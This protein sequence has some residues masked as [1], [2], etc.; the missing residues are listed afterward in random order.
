[1]IVI[2]RLLGGQACIMD[3]SISGTVSINGLLEPDAQL[4][5]FLAKVCVDDGV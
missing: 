4:S 3:I 1:M 2:D 5:P